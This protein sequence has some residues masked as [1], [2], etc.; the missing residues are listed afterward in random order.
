MSPAERKPSPST[1]RQALVSLALVI[2]AS[3]V[4]VGGVVWWKEKGAGEGSDPRSAAM[5]RSA[6]A[7]PVIVDVAHERD[8]VDRIEALGTARANESVTITA[9][10]ADTVST[11]NFTD[12]MHVEQGEI[13]IELASS[14]A[15]AE[16][17]QARASLAEAEKQYARAQ[18][19]MR[20]GTTTR[21]NLDTALAARDVSR[22]RVEAIEAR[23]ADRIVRAP[24]SGMLG[25]RA[26]SLG[27]LVRPG[28]TITTLDDV[29]RIKVDFSIPERF[30]PE[31][32]A[33]LAIEASAAAYPGETFR[34]TVSV[35]DTRVDPVTRAATVRAEIPNDD[36]RLKPGMLMML[37]VLAHARRS[38]SVSEVS[39]F[40]L[41]PDNYLFVVTDDGRAKRVKVETGARRPGEV[42][43]LSG[44]EE[45]ARVVVDGINRIGPGRPVKVVEERGA[46]VAA[47]EVGR[48]DAPQVVR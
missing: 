13:L 17:A 34:G 7:V 4:I 6:Q 24:F 40:P 33:G 42:E 31:V 41:G 43:I 16:L 8:F 22:A 26:V 9:K 38:I 21:S 29:S 37:E 5:A 25:L 39:V 30:L 20:S 45:G 44:I 3:A 28:D 1:P 15:A 18:D 11:I 2:L 19:L 32:G 35:V 27:T 14:E 10:V 36:G 23:L 47:S 48:A 12:G 46:P